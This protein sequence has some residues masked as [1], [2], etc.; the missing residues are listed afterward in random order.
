M[1]DVQPLEVTN[2]SQGVTDYSIDGGPNEA[3][4]LDN[5]FLRPN[6]K[7]IT[8]WGSV[9]EVPLQIPLGQF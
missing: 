3:E 4:S 1:I 2:F 6:A 7:P 9:V 8:R 5:F